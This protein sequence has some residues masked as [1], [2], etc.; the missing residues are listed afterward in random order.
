MTDVSKGKDILNNTAIKNAVL[1][2]LSPVMKSKGK[3]YL[4]DE[5]SY[6]GLD[7]AC[8]ILNNSSADKDVREF[9]R[10]LESEKI[11]KLFA[12]Y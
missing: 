6:T 12:G 2:A 9:T 11:R 5:K 8:V 3:Y 4:I 10:F 1:I 7:R